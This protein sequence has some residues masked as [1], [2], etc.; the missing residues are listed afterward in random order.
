[1]S[2]YLKSIREYGSKCDG[3]AFPDWRQKLQM[4]CNRRRHLHPDNKTYMTRVRFLPDADT[5]AS[6]AEA[7]PTKLGRSLSHT[8]SIVQREP[9]S[10]PRMSRRPCCSIFH[11]GSMTSADPGAFR[12]CRSV[13][14]ETTKMSAQ[15]YVTVDSSISLHA[16]LSR[17]R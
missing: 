16:S 11:I 3:R 14:L 9:S 13:L 7:E 5:D 6:L 2:T 10:F 15:Q 17:P 4:T 12:A 8:T 1:M